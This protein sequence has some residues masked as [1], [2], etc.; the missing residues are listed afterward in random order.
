MQNLLSKVAGNL[1]GVYIISSSANHKIY[2][3]SAACFIK[4]FRVHKCLLL[5]G[6][7]FS[8]PL[9]NH[10]NKYGIE[11]LSFQILEVCEKM[12]I[13]TCEQKWLDKRKPFGKVGFNTALAADSVM[14]GRKHS[15]LTLD[16]IKATA[17]ANG[18]YLKIAEAVRARSVGNKYCLGKRH[19][20]EVKAKI[21]EKSKGRVM[22]LENREMMRQLSTGRVMP[23]EAREKI[24]KKMMGNTRMLGVKRSDE[25]KQI[26]SDQ[27]SIAVIQLSLSGVFIKQWPSSKLAGDSLSLNQAN[28]S[29]CCNGSRKT[30]GGYL[31]KKV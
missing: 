10:V 29:S 1:S 6:K 8:K 24:S 7:H 22:S 4:R 16:K 19:S 26:L 13:V 9:Q 12:Q 23:T 27:K 20:D 30:C 17:V 25:T 21:G 28:I 11:V 15:Q 3:G 18:S 2:I 31:W 5:S 14:L